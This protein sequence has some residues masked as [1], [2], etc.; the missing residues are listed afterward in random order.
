MT[1]KEINECII[2]TD[3]NAMYTNRATNAGG[4]SSSQLYLLFDNSSHICT[5]YCC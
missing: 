2:S 4:V 1:V 5:S 3:D